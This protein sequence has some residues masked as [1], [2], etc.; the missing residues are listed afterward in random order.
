MSKVVRDGSSD[1]I[2]IVEPATGT[3]PITQLVFVLSTPGFVGDWQAAS[4][5][6]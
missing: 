6:R 1:E 2:Y 5:D 3:P 4:L